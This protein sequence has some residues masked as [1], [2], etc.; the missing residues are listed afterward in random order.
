MSHFDNKTFKTELLVKSSKYFTISTQIFLDL[1][2]QKIVNHLKY[3]LMKEQKN[4]I[5]INEN[6]E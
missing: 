6:T 4:R 2:S 1:H 3:S 5:C